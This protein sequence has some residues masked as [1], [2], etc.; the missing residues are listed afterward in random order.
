MM[1]NNELDRFSTLL[2]GNAIRNYR[3]GVLL[4]G[5]MNR[6]VMQLLYVD[7]FED[8]GPA[9]RTIHMGF[10]SSAHYLSEYLSE[11]EA[12]GVNDVALKPRFNQAGIETTLKRW[13]DAV[14]PNSA[15]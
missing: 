15:H 13:A 5:D 9:P 3:E 6:P 1:P 10:K 14:L 4:A 12:T 2:R 11:L 8:D 7:L